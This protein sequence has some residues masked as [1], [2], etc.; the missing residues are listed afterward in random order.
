M[1]SEDYDVLI[2]GSGA[3][4]LSAA[5]SM[6]DQKVAVATKSSLLESA[7]QSRSRWYCRSSRQG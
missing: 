5:L 7:R 6:P 4:A 1:K 2:L 3:A